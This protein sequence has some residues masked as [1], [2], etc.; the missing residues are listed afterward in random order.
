VENDFIGRK[1]A[2]KSIVVEQGQLKFF[3][4]ATGAANPIYFDQEAARAAGHPAV[5]APPTF[6]FSLD[7]LSPVRD[8]GVLREMGVSFANVLH[9]EQRFKYGQPIYAGDEITLVSEVVDVYEKKGGALTFVVTEHTAT[10]QRGEHVGS[11]I[12]SLVIRS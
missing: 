9:G 1:T 8:T 3:A 11:M 10:N 7:L 12:N 6:L 4:H 2:P 5:P